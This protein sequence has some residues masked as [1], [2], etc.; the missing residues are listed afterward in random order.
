MEALV[1]LQEQGA[2][3]M[4]ADR[5]RELLWM[6]KAE[7]HLPAVRQVQVH[8]DMV[9]PQEVYIQVEKAEIML[10]PA[11]VDIMAVVVE[12]LALAVAPQAAVVAVRHSQRI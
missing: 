11:E 7:Q 9:K 5:L 12:L 4:R 2:M 8:L 10:V 3:E 6:V 1:Q